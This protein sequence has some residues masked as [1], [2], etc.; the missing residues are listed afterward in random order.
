MHLKVQTN[1]KEMFLCCQVFPPSFRELPPPPLELFDLDE[2]F[3]SEQSRLAQLANKCGED[4]LEYFIVAACEVFG[5]TPS[6]Q[7]RD[8]RTL[9]HALV[10]E[11]ATF[12]KIEPL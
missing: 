10:S 1:L 9:L 4:D 6:S 7:T 2:A 3:S 12:K 11:V 5:V 8:A